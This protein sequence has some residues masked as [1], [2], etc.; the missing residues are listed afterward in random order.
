MVSDAAASTAG[1]RDRV[2]GITP[3]KLPS[4]SRLTTPRLVSVGEDVYALLGFARD[5]FLHGTVSL[6]QRIHLH[7]ED[8]AERLLA[9]CGT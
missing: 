2:R 9:R 1:P 6:M 7:D 8:L 3:W 5:E 4:A